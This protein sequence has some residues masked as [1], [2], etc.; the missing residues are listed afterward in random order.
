MSGE[1][2]ERRRHD[3]HYACLTE[4]LATVNDIRKDV[5]VV[6][7]VQRELG[8][9]SESLKQHVSKDNELYLNAFPDGDPDAHRRTH[10]AAIQLAEERAEFWRKMRIKAGEMTLWAFLI[11]LATV[12][13][14]YWNGHMPASAHINLPN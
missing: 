13:V 3:A 9:V 14:Y 1:L 2:P 6:H 12:A 7:Q 4:I 10:E 11:C 8:Q 5:D